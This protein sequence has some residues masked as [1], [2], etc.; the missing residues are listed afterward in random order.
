MTLATN[1]LAYWKADEASGNLLDAHNVGPYDGTDNG[2]V[3]ATTKREFGG[4]RGPNVVFDNIGFST[5]LIGFEIT[6][7]GTTVIRRDSTATII[8]ASAWNH[9]AC[10]Y[11]AAGQTMDI[12]INGTLR[13]GTLTGS[14]PASQFTN[15]SINWNVGRKPTGDT[16]MAGRLDEM[17]I[18]SRALDSSEVTTLYGSGTPPDYSTFGGGG[19]STAMAA[20][21]YYNLLAG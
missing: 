3:G 1:L 16:Y 6:S 7:D 17:G 12:Y 21:Q 10:V 13:N 5:R 2:S 11:D 8:T 4:S 9:V 18:W 19:G 14:V 15:N 20:A